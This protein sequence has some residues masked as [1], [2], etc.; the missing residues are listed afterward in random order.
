MPNTLVKKVEKAEEAIYQDAD[1][2]LVNWEANDL[3]GALE[4]AGFSAVEE[5]LEKQVDRRRIGQAQFDRWFGESGDGKLSYGE[6]LGEGDIRPKDKERVAALY[7]RQL[8]EQVVA[9]ETM[10]LVYIA[11]GK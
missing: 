11:T 3:V 7:R 5:R 1:D 6:R 8:L 2:P 10:V 4:T 9:W